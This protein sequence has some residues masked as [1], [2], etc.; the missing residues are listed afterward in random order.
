MRADAQKTGDLQ[1]M[2]AWAGQSAALGRSQP[3]SG[4]VRELWES[5]RAL[6]TWVE[7]PK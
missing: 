5:A 2:Q 7:S 3:A 1:R 6:S 4:M